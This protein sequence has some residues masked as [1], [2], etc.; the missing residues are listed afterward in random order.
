MYCGEMV[1]DTPLRIH[2]NEFSKKGREFHQYLH[3]ISDIEEPLGKNFTDDVLGIFPELSFDGELGIHFAEQVGSGDE[4][5]FHI[6]AE[7]EAK[8][9][10]DAIDILLNH[11]SCDKNVSA[12]WAI[13]LICNA[14]AI[15]PVFWHGAY[16]CRKYV[17]SAKETNELKQL[18]NGDT[19]LVEHFNDILPNVTMI[20]DGKA[21]IKCCYW[22]DWKGLVCET[23][24]VDFFNRKCNIVESETLYKYNC[25]IRF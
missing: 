8:Y 1:D 15:L 19:T 11:I 25:G 10:N 20:S 21:E 6:K 13:Y 22:N 23:S 12:A 9:Q 16:K 5:W 17:F 7:L 18:R 4:S 3:D 14:N 24:V 2:G